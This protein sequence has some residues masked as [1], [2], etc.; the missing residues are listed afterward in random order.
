M[1]SPSKNNIS[2]SRYHDNEATN[3]LTRL[4]Q[5]PPWPLKAA[6]KRVFLDWQHW[7][8]NLGSFGFFYIFSRKQCLRQQGYCT[9]KKKSLLAEFYFNIFS[10]LI[11]R[12]RYQKRSSIFVWNL[13]C[14]V[15]RQQL[16]GNGIS[17][18]RTKFY[19]NHNFSQ[20]QS[21]AKPWFQNVQL[22]PGVAFKIWNKSNFNS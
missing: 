10:W 4:P 13:L 12:W 3:K 16:L 17:E 8:A 1:T 6:K 18:I 21:L 5:P 2:L 15:S 9:P 14:H 22:I 7:G 19:L 20:V 11:R